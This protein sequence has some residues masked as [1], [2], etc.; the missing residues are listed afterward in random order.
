MANRILHRLVAGVVASTIGTTVYF[1]SCD[2]NSPETELKDDSLPV[3]S[4]EHSLNYAIKKAEE[5]C[6]RAKD[7]S[8]SPGLVVGVSVDGV[9]LF[10]LG[11]RL[12]F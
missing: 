10:N 4:K 3:R 2:A 8:G 12:L 6:Q 7:E 9:N 11:A 5:L 1:V